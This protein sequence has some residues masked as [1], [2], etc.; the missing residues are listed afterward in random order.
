M[1]D[2]E[3]YKR[4]EEEISR[5]KKG[6]KVMQAKHQGHAERQ[7]RSFVNEMSSKGHSPWRQQSDCTKV[8]IFS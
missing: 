3:K 8:K 2:K 1:K 5:R 7:T 6:E 4:W